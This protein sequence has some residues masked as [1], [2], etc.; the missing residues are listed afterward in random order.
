MVYYKE[1]KTS[2]GKDI[3]FFLALFM[4]KILIL[5]WNAIKAHAEQLMV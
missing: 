5:A 2:Q 1:E 4:N 3:I